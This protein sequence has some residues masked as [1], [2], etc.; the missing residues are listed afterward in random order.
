[1]PE[2]PRYDAADRFNKEIYHD[3]FDAME[4]L[5]GPNLAT[6]I[7]AGARAR[8][9]P[10][11]SLAWL[12]PLEA[13]GRPLALLHRH[14][15]HATAPTRR[16]TAAPARRPRHSR[17]RRLRGAILAANNDAGST[18]TLP[19]GTYT[20]TIHRPRPTT[21]RRAT[22]T[23]PTALTIQG[24]GSGSTII[25][26]GTTAT[27]GIDKI[28]SFNPLG[29][30]AGFPVSLSGLTIRFGRNQQTNF[31]AGEY[32]GGAFDFDAGSQFGAAAR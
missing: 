29:N 8:R 32:F 3:E 15:D 9:R 26:A 28:F 6:G 17:W 24:A 23:S 7:A 4:P 12:E 2:P 30:F 20:L 16:S 14:R 18:I 10:V 25:Q 27:N 1:M 19:A 5:V 11:I 22:S 31:A 21:P 13:A